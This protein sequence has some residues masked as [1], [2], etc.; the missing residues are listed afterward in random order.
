MRLCLI[1]YLVCFV[2]KS[3]RPNIASICTF[4]F[5]IQVVVAV[6]QVIASLLINGILPQNKCL[7]RPSILLRKGQKE[8]ARRVGESLAGVVLDNP[9][10]VSV[11]FVTSQRAYCQ[12]VFVSMCT[13]SQVYPQ[14]TKTKGRPFPM[15]E[16]ETGFIAAKHNGEVAAL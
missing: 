8:E 5:C 11:A 4:Y 1:Y 2:T 7:V 9:L 12:G 3:Q 14:F 6:A 16:K 13:L 10:E 15:E